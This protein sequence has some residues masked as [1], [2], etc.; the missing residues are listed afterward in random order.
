MFRLICVVALA[1][2]STVR[3]QE[4]PPQPPADVTASNGTFCD[5]VQITWNV[6][7]GATSY[8][9]LRSTVNSTAT[10]SQIG[11]IATTTFNDTS[12]NPLTTYW[13]WVKASDITGQSGF[14]NG[15]DGFRNAAPAAVTGLTASDDTF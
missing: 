9:I 11:S 1:L 10:A 2:I 5:R 14:S 13:Y 4:F 6:S 3:A 12:A 15:D 8:Q 7:A